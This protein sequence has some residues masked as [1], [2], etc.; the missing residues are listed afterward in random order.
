MRIS[1]NSV[2][3]FQG[4]ECPV[5]ILS[6]TRSNRRNA[7]GFVDDS[8]RLNVA[9]SRARKKLILIGDTET[10]TRRVKERPDGSKDSRAAGKERDFFVQL[11]RYVEGHGK[12][13]RVFERRSIS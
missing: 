6:F 13:M 11:I 10:L 1:V 12:T 8:N 3:A 2:D 9:L 5:I 7:V 4:K